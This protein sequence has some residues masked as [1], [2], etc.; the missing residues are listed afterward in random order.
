MDTKKIVQSL[1][2]AAALGFSAGALA[3]GNDDSRPGF[4]AQGFHRHPVF[5]ENL[6]LIKDVNERQDRQTDRILKGF[7][8]RRITLQEFRKL[9]DR[10]RDI[11]RM[12]RQFL[13]DGLVSRHEYQRLD[14][15]LDSADRDIFM[16]AHDAQGR[17]SHGAGY[18]NWDR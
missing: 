5:Q 17:P 14:A 9:M 4:D 18:G 13:A 8:E 1:G 11:Q 6:R 15:A 12:A 10:Q 16:E 7:Y 2:L 3:H